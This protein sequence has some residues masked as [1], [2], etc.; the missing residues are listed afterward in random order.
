MIGCFAHLVHGRRERNRRTRR[1]E[2]AL[3]VRS[4][5]G[6]SRSF[7]VDR[8]CAFETDASPVRELDPNVVA[9]LLT[10]PVGAHEVLAARF[11]TSR[12]HTVT[13]FPV[14]FAAVV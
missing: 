3:D 11:S 1:I 10:I 14:R 5:G 12:A 13:V 6:E 4:L 2:R 8:R 7:R 9:P